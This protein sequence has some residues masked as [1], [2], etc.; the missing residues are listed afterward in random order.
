MAKKAAT[1]LR[2]KTVD[3]L[4]DAREQLKKEM[5]NLRFQQASGQLEN[6]AAMRAARRGVAR[7][8]TILAERRRDAAAAQG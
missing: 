6:T 4:K 8:E 7:I 3:E 2:T 5:F 1:D